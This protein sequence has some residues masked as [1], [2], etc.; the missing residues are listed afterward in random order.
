MDDVT[1][2]GVGDLLIARQNYSPAGRPGAGALTI[3][4]G[5]QA[6]RDHA[7]TLASLDLRAPPAAV[8]LLTLV[9]AQAVDRLGIW[10]RTGD[11]TGDGIADIVVG[12]DQEDDAGETDRGAAY[13]VRGGAHLATTSTIDLAGFGATPLAGHVVRVLPPVG[14][15]EFHFGATCQIADLDGNGRGEVLVAAALARAGA[16]LPALGAPLGSAHFA[17]GSPRGTVYIAWDDTFAVNPWPAGLTL[18]AGGAAGT[19]TTIHGRVGNVRFGK[20]LLGGD[21]YDH[22]R[23]ADLFIGDLVGDGTPAQDRPGSGLGHVIF[24]AASL[25]GLAFGLDA[26]PAG[27]VISTFLGGA[28]G[29]ISAD[30]AASGDFDGDG[31]AD[32]AFSSPHADP[33]GRGDAGVLYVF[34]GQGVPWPSLL[35]LAD[36]ASLAG[37][38]ITEVLGA[39]GAQ[40]ADA[41][42]TLCYSAAAGHVDAD[43]RLDIITNEMQGNGL[44]PGTEDVG[45]LIIL[46]GA[47]VAGRAGSP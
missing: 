2:N 4:V 18:R 34:H 38:R 9:G 17:G 46:G 29:D 12:A 13:L 10:M 47:L 19:W 33:L 41:G 15:N 32:L 23:S 6:L 3:V 24:R 11:V 37:V 39:H 5:G 28:A 44:G 35:D 20:E 22:D 21:D 36:L 27:L 16:A 43:G 25:K 1:G 30:T 7:A 8:T 45:N 40:G 31:I 26:P 42:D 14:A